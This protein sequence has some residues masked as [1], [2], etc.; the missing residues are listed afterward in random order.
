M[1]GGVAKT[2]EAQGLDAA[3]LFAEVGLSIK[4]LDDLDYRWPTEEASRLWTLAT[5]RSGNPDIGLSNPICRDRT[6]AG[7]SATP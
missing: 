1:D 5:E 4:D 7:S 6:N 2:F 3:A